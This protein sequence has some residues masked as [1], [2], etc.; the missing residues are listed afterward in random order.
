VDAHHGPL[1]QDPLG[2][3]WTAQDGAV[4]LSD[5]IDYYSTS[6]K[7]NESEHLIFPFNEDSLEAARYNLRL[8]SLAHVGG[9]RIELTENMPELKLRPYQVAV[10][11]TLEEIRLPRFLIARW[12]LK[13]KM[14]YEGLLWTGAL[15][16]DPG[17]HGHLYCPLYNLA[18]RDVV[19]TFR[20][21]LFAMDF[22]RTTQFKSGRSKPYPQKP[23]G[24]EE[25]DKYRLKSAPYELRSRVQVVEEKQTR[26]E[27]KQTRLEERNSVHMTILFT[28]L[29]VI[30]AALA[31]FFGVA[32]TANTELTRKILP[33]LGSVATFIAALAFIFSIIAIA[34]S[35]WRPF[36][37]K[38][39]RSN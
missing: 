18:D 15:Q 39:P 1:E 10:V 20:Q 14:V 12:N 17:W 22:V 26:L 27:E 19:L 6:P 5:K 7:I 34:L 21:E 37:R 13:V 9:E 3:V 33:D 31:A 38:N 30:M 2:D 16:V 28:V 23:G 8:G 35:Y 36:G 4:L 32:I 25:F 29:A 11:Q 24:L